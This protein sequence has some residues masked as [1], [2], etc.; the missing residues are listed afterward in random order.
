MTE[1]YAF[2]R[3][4]CSV[5]LLTVALV[6]AAMPW[7]GGAAG[8]SAGTDRQSGISRY[9]ARYD[10]LL[11]SP[12]DVFQ[13]AQ[14]NGTVS[15]PTAGGVFDVALT[16]HDIRAAEYRADEVG[17]DGLTGAVES[18]PA[19]T[20]RGT[21][22][23]RPEIEARFTITRDKLE[24]IIV[25]S[26]EL[27]FIEPMKN[28]E[29]SASPS[30]LV[31]YSAADVRPG[32][33]GTC[34]TG[35]LEKIGQAE[36]AIGPKVL[37]AN[38]SVQVAEVA[39]EA[40]YEYVTA[41][42]GSSAANSA[43]LEILNQVD[44]IYTAQLSISLRVTYQHSW[45]TFNDPYV[46]TNPSSMLTEFRTYWNQNLASE[47]YDLAHM[48]TGKDMDGSTIGI[49]FQG[50]VCGARSY[51]YGISQRF[52]SAPGK[53]IL[54][55]HEI[56]H[57]FGA[58]HTDD[59]V[60]PQPACANTIMNAYIGSGTSFCPY[61]RTE[62]T[63]YAAQHSS[64]LTDATSTCPCDLNSD[65]KVDILDIQV[66]VNRILNLQSPAISCDL[67]K[68]GAVNVLD[69]QFLANVVLGSATCP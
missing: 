34:A 19:E 7:H 61:S 49:A 57:N 2:L 12:T 50:V 5:R 15:L 25:T 14:E 27:Y 4:W 46:A 20:Y 22:P 63:S 36:Q 24:G 23:G 44:G 62:I 59:A 64:C 68:D 65:G 17:E 43:I 51:S 13:I 52:S 3:K 9:L 28:Y 37:L 56:G 45:A 32:A 42:G 16:R 6:L 47:I 60:P 69:L 41:M 55:A 58:S 30:E 48:W 26:D 33:I 18:M 66:L 40:D 29:E 31:T 54:T 10:R 53:Y 38:A 67:N 21:V 8:V 39:T 35:L 1:K 11:L